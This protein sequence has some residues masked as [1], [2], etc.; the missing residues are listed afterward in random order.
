[1]KENLKGIKFNPKQK[2]LRAYNRPLSPDG[3][4]VG[5]KG[6][7]APEG[8][9]VKIAGLK[10]LQFTGR[11]RCFDNEESAMKA[12][13]SRK[14]KDGD[15]IIIRYEGP[16]GGPGMR[17]MLSTTGAIYG[18]GKGEKVALITDGR[19]SGGTYGLVV[20]HI[21]PEAAVGG[22][23]ALIKQGD[24]ITVDAVKQLIEVDLSDEELEK[25][26]KDWVKPIQ[27]YIRGILSKYSRI[28]STSSLGAV[29]D[30]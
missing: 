27:K 5:L 8:G 11:A 20:G 18:Q 17:E 6:N 21:D 12:V 22:N 30:L 2:V 10:K 7:L 29:T 23:I 3:G 26:K 16:V 1:M 4:V 14:Y 24:L 28:V 9:T 25:R 15:V 13:Q 19:F